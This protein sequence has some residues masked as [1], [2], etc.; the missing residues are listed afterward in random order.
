L[1]LFDVILFGVW[2]VA[3]L[4]SDKNRESLRDKKL[5]MWFILPPSFSDNAFVNGSVCDLKN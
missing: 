4:L 1:G 2:S 5:Q 3:Q